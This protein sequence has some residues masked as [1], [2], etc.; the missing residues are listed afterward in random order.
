MV[1]GNWLGNEWHEPAAMRNGR[2]PPR[3]GFRK[4]AYLGLDMHRGR[5]AHARGAGL[6]AS[7][8]AKSEAQYENVCRGWSKFCAEAT[9][10]GV[11]VV[12]LTPGTALEAMPRADVPKAWVR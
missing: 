8:F 7:G 2:T 9:R 5:G 12:N 1:I 3:R 10:R 6:H 4:L 11:E